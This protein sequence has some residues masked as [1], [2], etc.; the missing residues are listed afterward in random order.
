MFFV[1]A[2]KV[3]QVTTFKINAKTAQKPLTQKKL[4]IKFLL[5]PSVLPK[6]ININI[7]KY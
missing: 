4:T 2:R 3:L 7:L 1:Y 6:E 5:L